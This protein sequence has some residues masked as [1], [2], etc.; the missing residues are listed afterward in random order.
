VTYIALVLASSGETFL[1]VEEAEWH[2]LDAAVTDFLTS[3]RSRDGILYLA[4]IDGSQ[5]AV[6]L[7]DIRS[8]ALMTP[9]TRRRAVEL[10]AEEDVERMRVLED[11]GLV[12][13]AEF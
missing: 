1:P 8:W 6:L 12:D 9:E 4:R 10:E 3:G 11:L 7:S 2:R 5:V 13:D